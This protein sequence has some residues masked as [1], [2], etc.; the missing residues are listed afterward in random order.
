[1]PLGTCG[2]PS[3]VAASVNPVRPLRFNAPV[4][5]ITAKDAK[6]VKVIREA[7]YV[8]MRSCF[9]GGGRAPGRAPLPAD[10]R[11]AR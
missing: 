10:A 3:P 6:D 11:H 7:A 5:G 4:G 9:L 2:I 1:M 8:E